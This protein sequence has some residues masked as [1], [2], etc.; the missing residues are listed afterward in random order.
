[1]LKTVEVERAH[2]QRSKYYFI[3]RKINIGYNNPDSEKGL[4][5]SAFRPS[6]DACEYP[7]HIPDNMFL[8][9]VLYKLTSI[10]ESEL[11]DDERAEK[12]KKLVFEL[13]TLI[14][15]YGIFEDEETGKRYVSETDCMGHYLFNDDANIPSLLSIPYL[16]YPYIDK[17]VYENTRKFILSKRNKYYYEGRALKGI[18]SP[19][20]PEGR[21]WPLSLCMQA[22]TSEDETEIK[23][24]LQMLFDSTDGT[25]YMHEGVDCNDVSAYSRPWFVW[26]NSMFAY[27]ILCKQNYFSDKQTQNIK[28]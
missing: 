25:G 28:L 9:S 23:E 2:S 11:K 20:T 12:C 19:H 13:K 26:A 14:E 24:I 27:M 8:V 1:M 10:F 4:V 3:R 5:W 7:Y 22:L 21:V 17:R 15:K 16:E 6:D 18:G